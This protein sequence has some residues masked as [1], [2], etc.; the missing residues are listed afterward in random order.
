LP[1][2]WLVEL[3]PFV[4]SAEEGAHSEERHR[5]AGDLSDALSAAPDRVRSGGEVHLGR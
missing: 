5:R 1:K 2:R 4:P 3:S